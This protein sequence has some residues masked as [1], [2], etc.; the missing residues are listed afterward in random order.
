MLLR[1][2]LSRD[3]FARRPV[4]CFQQRLAGGLKWTDNR[5][6]ENVHQRLSLVVR[7]PAPADRGARLARIRCVVQCTAFDTPPNRG[8]S[9]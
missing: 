8:A 9:Q 5:G 3:T 1:T 6:T 4:R 7:H 2:T